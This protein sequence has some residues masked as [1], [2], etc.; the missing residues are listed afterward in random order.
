MDVQSSNKGQN[1]DY[2]FYLYIVIK[3]E[4]SNILIIFG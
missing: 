3:Y 2:A 4:S 1:L